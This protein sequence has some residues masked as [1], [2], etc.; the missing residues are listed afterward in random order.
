[1]QAAQSRLLTSCMKNFKIKN[2]ELEMKKINIKDDKEAFMCEECG[3]TYKD[4]KWAE[5]CEAWCKK[6]NSCNLNI[7]S[8]AINKGE[9]K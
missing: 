8:Y 1:M 3:L 9:Q 4:K 6:Y 2:I 5:K 7:T